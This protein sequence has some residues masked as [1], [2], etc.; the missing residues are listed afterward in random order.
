MKR[1]DFVK[2]ISDNG[3]SV[4]GS[5]TKSVQY[6]ITTEEEA[7]NPT[8]KVTAAQNNSIPLVSEDFIVESV[9]EGKLLDPNDYSV[10]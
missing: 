3:G 10:E 6:L 4:A 5:V 1:A 2:L 7:S 9:K 8:T